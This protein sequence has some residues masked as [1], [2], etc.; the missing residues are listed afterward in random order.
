ML[1]K[2]FN[3]K[4]ETK[5]LLEKTFLVR[6][7]IISKNDKS[8]EAHEREEYINLMKEENYNTNAK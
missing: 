2:D 1:T 7:K 4:S 5:Q 8:C 6:S 3:I